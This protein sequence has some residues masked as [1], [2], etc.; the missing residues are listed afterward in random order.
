M[1]TT[2]F[3][4]KIFSSNRKY[5]LYTLV[6]TNCA[7]F[8]SYFGLLFYANKM[9]LATGILAFLFPGLYI[10]LAHKEYRQSH[11]R[12]A[13]LDKLSILFGFGFS[14]LLLYHVLNIDWSVFQ[15]GVVDILVFAGLCGFT[16]DYVL[17]L[18]TIHTSAQLNLQIELPN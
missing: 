18:M 11:R 5:A 15:A 10:L 6:F 12:V 2:T 9:S 16:K 17:E 13:S 14:V 4:E 3:V 7:I 1:K 8:I